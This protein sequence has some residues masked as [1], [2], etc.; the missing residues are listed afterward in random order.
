M[1]LELD[2]LPADRPPPGVEV[3]LHSGDGVHRALARRGSVVLGTALMA[4]DG[5]AG[6]IFDVHVEEAERRSRDNSGQII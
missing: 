2:A 1:G 3:E 6:S 5:A 4:V